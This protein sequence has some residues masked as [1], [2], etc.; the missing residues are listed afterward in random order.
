MKLYTKPG[1]CST[2]DHIALQWSGAPH[3]VE[4]MTGESLKSPEYLA[5]NPAG[6]VPVLVDGD[7]VLTQNAAIMGYIADRF[8]D[9][10]LAGDGSARDRAEATR[11]LAFVNAD[12]HPAFTPL[13]APGKFVAD[14]AQHAPLGDAARKRIR[15]LMETADRRLG[16]RDWL[17]GFRSFADPY[18]YMT[19]RWAHGLGVD[20]GGL[21]NV[22]AFKARM[23]ADAGVRKVLA[24]EGLA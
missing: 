13:F 2:A 16:G 9:G 15:G 24:D 22:A 11:W 4:V 14:E 21:D 20:M 10:G 7:F 18:F 8:P 19:V 23:E 1:A 5:I 17:A 3:T 12:V 6:T